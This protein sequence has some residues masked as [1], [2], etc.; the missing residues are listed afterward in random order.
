MFAL[1][2]ATRALRALWLAGAASLICLCPCTAGATQVA[3]ANPSFEENAALLVSIAGSWT[4]GF[5]PQ[6]AVSGSAGIFRPDVPLDFAADGTAVLYMNSPATVS[7]VLMADATTPLVATPGMAVRVNLAGRARLGAA[8]TITITLQNGAG[9]SAFAPP[10]QLAIPANQAGYTELAATLTLPENLGALAGQSL[11]LAITNSGTQVNLDHVR[12]VAAQPTGIASFTANPAEIPVGGSATLTWDV[13]N[14]T[15]VTLNGTD[16]TALDHLTVTP[17]T[18]TVYTL[19]ANGEGGGT[20]REAVVVV[21]SHPLRI[22]EIMAANSR[23]LQ[24]E[25]GAWSDW[26]EIHNS[27]DEVASLD[28]LYLTDDRALKPKWRFPDGLAIQPRGHLVVFASGKDRR[29]AGSELHTNFS[30]KSEGEYLA[31]VA[32]DGATVLHALAPVFPPLAP[33]SSYGYGT[34][35]ATGT[36]PLVGAGADAKYLVP[37]APLDDAWRGGGVFDDA[38]WQNGAFDF[39]YTSAAP[40]V[41]AYT[42][43]AGTAGNQSYSG[44]LGM[45]F[46]V[47]APVVVTAVGCFDSGSNGIAGSATISTQIFVRNDGG[48]PT[49]PADDTAGAALLAQP[50]A[51]T[52]TDP[53]DPGDGHRFKPL[54]EPL[55]LAPGAYTIVSW[56][57]NSNNRNGNNAS[58]FSATHDGGGLLAFTGT[59]RY[60]SAG[61]FP[62]T[63]DNHVAQYGAGTFIYHGNTGGTFN[64]PTGEAMKG[65]NAS[66]FVRKTFQ[67]GPGAAYHSLTLGI[68]ADDGYVAW[69][70][71]VEIARRN[72]PTTL[73][74]DASATGDGPVSD[75]LTIPPG[76]LVAGSNILAI[77]GLNR[78][79]DGD[80][81]HLD[82]TLTGNTAT[83]GM[84]HLSEPTPGA[85]NGTGTFANHIV[86][87][88]I[89]ADPPDGKWKFV[90]FVEL[91]NPLAVPVDISGWSFSRGITYVFPSGSVLA[92][93]GR[94]VVAEN[95]THLNQYLGYPDALGP[96]SGNLDG[97]G[98]EI[99][100]V[101]T[102]GAV[103]DSVSYGNGF[104]WPTVG[105]EP[106]TSIQRLH[107]SLD[108]ELGGSWRSAAPTP[109]T[110][111]ADETPNAPPAIRQVLHAPASPVAGQAVLV[112]AKVT[113]PAGVSMVWLEYQMVSPGSYIR[114]TDPEWLAQWASLPMRDDGTGGDAVADDDIFTVIVPSTV[115][116]HRQLVRYRIGARDSALAPVRVPYA[117]DPGRNFAWFCYD[118][119]P[120]WTGAVQPGSTPPAT[121][122]VETMNGVRPW[123]L[124]SREGDVLSCQYNPAYDNGSY[125]FEGA[126]V[127]DG[128]VFD[129]VR[130]RVKGQNSTFV[131]GKNKWKIKFNLGHELGLRDDRDQPAGTVRTLNLS[132]LAEPWAEWNRG[133]A[134]IDEA[135]SFKLFNLAGVAAPK[136]RFVQFRVIDSA[137]ESNPSDQYEGDIWGLYL[138]FGNL[139]NQFK[140]TMGLPDGN[141]FQLEQ[142]ANELTGQGK[143]Q[144][145][146]LSDINSFAE[147][148]QNAAQTEQ[149]FR[150]NVD[151]ERY[152]S[153]RAITE[154]VNNT[155]RREFEN[156][157]YF[158]NPQDGRW[159]IHPWDS[160]LL[161]EQL[162]RWGPQGVQSHAAYEGVQN[163]LKHTAIRIEWQNRCR[164]L[165][166]LLL[167]SDQAW[168]VIDET[169]A[170]ATGNESRIIPAIPE[171]PLY[172]FDAGFVEVDRRMWDWHPR[173]NDKGIFYRN[174]Y[175]IGSSK[176]D[177][178]PY[179]VE[180]T[181]AT[182]D[183]PGMLK[184]VKDFI[185]SD[186][187]GGGRL[188]AM[189]AGTT[190]PL[191]LATGETSVALPATP[192]ISYAGSGGFPANALVFHSSPFAADAGTG[193]AAMEWRIGEVSH[194]GIPGYY[195]SQPWVYEITPVWR[196]PSLPSFDAVVSPPASDLLPG[197]TYR[198][199]VRHRNLA[200]H[201]SHWSAPLE[202]TAGAAV[203][204]NLAADLVI[205]EIMYNPPE[206]SSLEFIELYNISTTS[207]LILDGL[208]F[209]EGID[210]TFPSGLSLGPRS[211]AL[212][213]RDR[214]AFEAKYGTGLPIL[215]EWLTT[216][217]DNGGETL[218]LS[219]AGTAIRVVPYDD[220]PPWPTAADGTG[221]SLVLVAPHLNPDH[222]LAANWRAGEATPGHTD[223]PGYAAW[224]Q[225]LNLAGD[226]DPD[227]DGVSNL[228][229]YALGGNPL[230]CDRAIIPVVGREADGA[231]HFTLTR[232]LLAE[233]VEWQLQESDDLATWRAAEGISALSSSTTLTTETIEFSVPPSASNP[234]F[235]RFSF[236]VR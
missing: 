14:A 73:G 71:G 41:T 169:V 42:V 51:F 156:M 36:V 65:T 54:S 25:D 96:W 205:S 144:P 138:A 23:T 115:Q 10:Y 219:L 142:G 93:G 24:D 185:A 134:G 127:A 31:L 226:D 182:A 37:T 19:T 119:V 34:G 203:P 235:F 26:I 58:G 141:L 95:P 82:A 67:I 90:E 231:W 177:Q 201:W 110:A 151:L 145:G 109:G 130:Y 194:P 179:P 33:D 46:T 70:N 186:P 17:A 153:W 148:Y 189:A 89:H 29:V 158:R 116:Q 2:T 97:E 133:L 223:A 161:Y 175:P 77:Q 52:A 176:G 50:V 4:N 87:S 8:T 204:G 28:G 147:G 64:T 9:T 94:L 228:L 107:E 113:S 61:T 212:V 32:A 121:F 120:A 122:G 195:P 146:D 217:L 214:A 11:T 59:S 85:A 136:T 178:G 152:A 88:E 12:V 69:L 224:K 1:R 230:V 135:V 105:A 160:D 174:P 68:T 184:W 100:L 140:E 60:G 150:S 207:P 180:R 56:G 187:H 35:P 164:E 215:G 183:Y 154:A 173:T 232:L 222:G 126:L 72:A 104:P 188:D 81:F 99:T 200:G 7:Q 162:D 103:V 159:S 198:A 210:F 227:G 181:L 233:D 213:V 40:D 21:R 236:N 218:T 78:T 102:S 45:D 57:Y 196:S 44:S 167:N 170:F 106:G 101:D 137:A 171:D 30:L 114:L 13:S 202:F 27:S 16:V 91:L 132:S 55:T 190:N 197:H 168:K 220:A 49:D 211:R 191:T 86:I 98:E 157:C 80:D 3:I 143:G 166:D 53:G 43:A 172:P 193:F 83:H 221:S 123:H 22:N 63:V 208:R 20:T 163:C 139:D 128:R 117:D 125:Q 62:G 6:W 48:T 18:S 124:L 47:N 75:Q 108:G 84:V 216:S 79:P 39:G 74:H 225:N 199:R 5:V 234:R 155:D 209:S 111:F 15:T 192:A 92:A 206:G 38:A 149:W 229:E 76:T 112:T 165:R 66:L 118:G 131:V 129:H